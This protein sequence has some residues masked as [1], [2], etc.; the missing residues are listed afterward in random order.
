MVEPSI[1]VVSGVDLVDLSFRLA[2][3]GPHIA[4]PSLTN[5]LVSDKLIIDLLPIIRSNAELDIPVVCWNF[6]S[7]LASAICRRLNRVILVRTVSIAS[8]GS[9]LLTRIAY[10]FSPYSE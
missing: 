5:S 10:A 8:V 4:N 6:L 7:R 9:S 2:T 3:L 1:I